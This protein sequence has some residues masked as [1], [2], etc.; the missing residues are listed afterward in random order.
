MPVICK[1]GLNF[2]ELKTTIYVQTLLDARLLS[3]EGFH[4]RCPAC[5]EEKLLELTHY[6]L[7][8]WKDNQGHDKLYRW[9]SAV[10]VLGDTPL[11]PTISLGQLTII[12]PLHMKGE[13]N[14]NE[15]Q[16]CYKSVPLFREKNGR[17]KP[18]ELPVQKEYLEMVDSEKEISVNETGDGN[19]RFRFRLRVQ[20]PKD[21]PMEIVL[22]GIPVKFGKTGASGSAPAFEGVHLILWPKM[23]CRAWR[24]YFLRF[25]CTGDN[26]DDIV[27]DNREV[28]VWARA[29]NDLDKKA[30]QRDWAKLDTMTPD[31][32]TRF[33]CV[34]GRPDWIAI[35]FRDI[36]R[37]DISGGALWRIPVPQPESFPSLGDSTTLGVD[38]G[39]SNTCLA[40]QTTQ[41][42]EMMQ[43]ESCDDFIIEGSDLPRELEYSDTWLPRRGFGRNHALIPSELLM[44]KKIGELRNHR[45]VE[46]WK[47]VVDYSIPSS[48]VESRFKEEDY[49]IADFK[50]QH[51]IRDQWLKGQS[52]ELQKRYLE[53][54]LLLGFAQLAKED[55][56]DSSASVKFS[57]PLAFD[58]ETQENLVTVVKAVAASLSKQTGVNVGIDIQTQGGKEVIP[59]DEARAAARAA[60]VA[61]PDVKTCLYV[62]IGGGSTDIALLELRAGGR[63]QDR[64]SFICSFQY[65]G[66]AL[67]SALVEGSCLKPGCDITHFRRQMREAGSVNELLNSQALFARDKINAITKKSDYFYAY[68]RH[69]LARLLAAHIINKQLAA[70]ITLSENGEHPQRETYSFMLYPLGNGWGFGHFLG[71]GFAAGVFCK[72]LTADA[73]RVLDEAIAKLP[74]LAQA[75]RIEVRGKTVEYPK[76][77]VAFGLLDSSQSG[78]IEK[79][80]WP[81]RSIVGWTTHGE[82]GS[83]AEWY[84]PVTMGNYEAPAGAPEMPQNSILDCPADSWPTFPRELPSPHELDKD[85]DKTRKYLPKCRPTAT[86]DTWLKY[87]PYHVLLEELFKPALKELV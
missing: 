32:K 83:K 70:A 18:P 5:Q 28:D 47:P 24:R 39:T 15:K 13:A 35:E 45:R 81:W 33:A 16:V 8:L 30:D 46:D 56:L 53:L 2:E 6:G 9:S 41:G 37:N 27:N 36:Q 78:N 25:G 86:S 77:A 69:F 11:G 26:A 10:T 3:P 60:A 87:S 1:C 49:V 73:N 19:F 72:Q 71:S 74:V 76:N 29:C 42:P 55:K 65:A 51:M 80:D 66:G 48:S 79:Q 40:W 50:W 17:I 59:I 14:F 34:E 85:L 7:F 57:Y 75:P 21:E 44:Q 20:D 43:I 4:L 31:K 67:A 61:G 68:L 84:Y 23:N 62:D 64:Y 54:V 58:E 22:P 52:M 82:G 12:F 63:Q 38:F